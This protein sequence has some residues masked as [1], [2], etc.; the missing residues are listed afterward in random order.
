VPL[1]DLQACS[2]ALTDEACH[3]H[4]IAVASGLESMV[5]G[6]PQILGQMK[7]A[8]A[9][10]QEAQTVGRHFY[11]LFPHIFS[12]AKRI[13]TDTAIGQNPVSV[14]YAAVRLARRIYADLSKTSALLIG[15]GETIELAAKHLSDNGI[16]RIVV[17]NRTLAR[18]RDLAERFGAEA[19]L[20]SDIPDQLV[21]ADI[22]IA[23]TASQLPI[24][25]KG[26]VERALK[27]R[28]HR[29]ILMIDIA[30]PR[31]IEPE[32]ADLRD[33]YLY[34]VDDLQDIINE[35]M[36]ARHEEARKADS[37]ID[38]GLAEYRRQ[39]RT[40][41]AVDT[42]RVYREQAEQQRD[43]ELERALRALERG[44]RAEAVMAE[45][46]RALTNKLIHVP[47]IGLRK[48]GERGELDR[49]AWLRQWL[50]LD[51]DNESGE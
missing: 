3:R 20:L 2:Y 11:R 48:A 9:T 40:L 43:A 34:S 17:A 29:P 39:L 1:T 18:A 12:T 31:D 49:I 33:V 25:G 23:S 26:A 45:L 15:A 14:A 46:A 13:R 24:L 4:L 22:V 36:R 10:A 44:E 42:L 28:R 47:S 38:T 27:Q 51:D 6:E 16:Q 32:V 50:A 19:V 37:L 5:L 35:N 7:S 30:V 8:F 21:H 41:D